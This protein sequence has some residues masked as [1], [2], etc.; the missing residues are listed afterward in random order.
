MADTTRIYLDNAATSW[1]KPEAVYQAVDRY[2][3]EVGAAAG[4]GAYAEATQVDAAITG[5]RKSIAKLIGAESHKSIVF[6]LNCT[7]SLNQAI[8]GVVRASDASAGTPHV[9]TTVVEHNSVLRPLRE[10]EERGEISVTRVPCDRQG[11]VDPDAVRQA[12][13][14]NT[15]LVA[16]LHASNVTGAL[17]PAAE[18]GKIVRETEAL[19]L[20][21]AAQTLGHLPLRV[22]DLHVDLLTA[23]G[24]KGLLGPLGTGVLY[25]RPGV[26]GQ[27]ASTRQGG[28][29]SQSDIDRQPENLPDK[30]ECGNL[31][32]P[33][34]LGV[35]AGVNYLAER[36]IDAIQQHAQQLTGQ[37]LD[38]L[39][40]LPGVTL[41]GPCDPQRQVGVVSF[42]IGD[43]DPRELAAVLDASYRVQARA[44]IHCAPRMHE[45]LGTLQT[46]GT[47]RFSVGA[48][49]SAAE[50][51]SALAAVA[52]VAEAAMAD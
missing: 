9:V 33:G 40:N 24:H 13:T 8:H 3:R 34:I 43:F 14:P 42:T 32:V 20:L 12:I 47:L 10:L 15:R 19:Y 35:G 16:M 28:T 52:E 45:S 11:I 26:E 36:G 21:D 22:Q 1:P 46:G 18:V 17:Q 29:G 37:L 6:T 25:V 31:N 2:Q 49:T 39:Q 50:I 23:A 27:V 38:G 44:G 7:D 30:F 4:R 51:E 41:Y 5:V 48:F